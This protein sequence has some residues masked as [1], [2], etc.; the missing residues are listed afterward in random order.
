MKPKHMAS[1]GIPRVIPEPQ[2]PS[3]NKERGKLHLCFLWGVLSPNKAHVREKS[4]ALGGSHRAEIGR[5]H[6]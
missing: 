1:V 2:L 4:E 3:K 5:A 6:V